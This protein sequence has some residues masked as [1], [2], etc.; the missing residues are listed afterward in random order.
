M[1]KGTVLIVDDKKNVL[2]ALDLL[3]QDEFE[4]IITLNN[5]KTLVSTLQTNSIDVVLLDM[6]YTAGMANGN[7]GIFWL[8]EI[9]KYDK[10]IEVVLFT[11]YGDVELAVKALKEGACDFVLKPWDNSKLIATLNSALKLRMSNKKV[12]ELETKEKSLRKEINKESQI[13]IGSSPSM[14]KIKQ[15][16]SKVAKTDANIL[17]TGENGTGKEVIAREI[18]RQSLRANELLVTVDVSAL[19]ETLIESELFGHKKGAFTDARE[20]RVGKFQLAHKGTLFLDELGNIPLSVQSKLLVAL[21]TRT[22]TPVGSNKEIPVDIR[23]ITATNCDIDKMIAE[24]RFREDLLYRINTINVE[25]PPLRDRE[26]DIELLAHHFL[27]RYCSKYMKNCRELS[28]AT[29]KKLKKYHWPGNVRELEHTIE[30]AVILSDS[31]TIS[32][33]SFFFKSTGSTRS[34]VP[35]T[36]EEM[37]KQLIND[38]IE[39]HDG[40]LSLAAKQLGVT[41]QTLYNKLKKYDV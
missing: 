27:K 31:N 40:N 10:T 35:L 22:I 8:N 41:R 4:E 3:L 29:L 28:S 2:N 14:L 25:L 32:P 39:K 19:P 24:N 12:S 17:I 15:L 20:D 33:D 34:N 26:D 16:V 1:A 5:P 6:N 13:L 18:H 21:Q 38:S 9:K 36:L 23:L 11:A 30:K 37:E 7:E